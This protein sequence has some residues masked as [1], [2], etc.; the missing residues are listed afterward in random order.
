MVRHWGR[1]L[2]SRTIL[3][4]VLPAVDPLA[5]APGQVLLKTGIPEKE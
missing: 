5:D 4:R 2:L 3:L 1:F